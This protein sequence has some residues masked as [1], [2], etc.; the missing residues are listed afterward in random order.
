MERERERRNY[1]STRNGWNSVSVPSNYD[2]QFIGKLR[3]PG[4]HLSLLD[5]HAFRQISVTVSDI[6]LAILDARAKNGIHK[7][8][9]TEI[10]RA[11]RENM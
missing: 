1:F 3:T 7:I 5:Y 8:I 10:A 6:V 2:G 9:I 11:A 4:I